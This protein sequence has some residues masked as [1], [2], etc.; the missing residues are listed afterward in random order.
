[1]LYD[2]NADTFTVSRKDFSTLSGAYAASSYN[3]YIV[4]SNLLNASL[5]P[6]GVLETASG[7]PSGFAFIDQGGFRTTTSSLSAPGIIESFDPTQGTATGKP[8]RL[9]EAPLLPT[10]SGSTGV[11]FPI[12]S[13]SGAN[14][15]M[16]F[17][18]SLA[19]LYD[20]SG[21]ISLSVSGFTVLPWDYAAAVAPPKI[22]AVV[23]AADGTL[24]VAPG[25]LISVYGQ[26]MSPVNLATSEIPLP[27]AL[28]ESCLTVNGVPVP[29]LFVSSQQING[30][31]P[32]NVDGN[33]QMTLRTPGGISDNFNFSI[34]PA[35]PAI[36]RTGIAGPDTGIA[37]IT[38]ADNGQLITPTNPVH[39]GDS[40]VIWSTGLGH[41]SPA[42]DAGIASPADPL[43]GAVIFP[44]VTL[45]G[46]GLNILY[47]GLTPGS[48]GLN[49]INAT[50]PKS[51]PLGLSIP[52]VILQG[53]SSTTL[54]VRVVK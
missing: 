12:G 38:R 4:G 9:V 48:V 7:A 51:V 17:L 25:G 36:F 10:N 11:T 50:V 37:T 24:P 43:A 53:G 45:G 35:A 1:M 34:L 16:S 27:T 2:A 33:A 40:I 28:G 18:R 8:T 29:I 52:L 46:V 42:I 49:Q 39:P 54:N 21:V 6:A 5:V 3:S 20:R 47:A 32:F 23:N 19:P 14:V 44:T 31:L 15:G 13:G 26:Q 22:N 41:T 30:Q